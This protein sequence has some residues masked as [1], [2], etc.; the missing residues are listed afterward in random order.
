VLVLFERDDA[1]GQGQGP[2]PAQAR[3]AGEPGRAGHLAGGAGPLG[4]TAGGAGLSF[5]PI[6]SNE[7]FIAAG[8]TG[9]RLGPIVSA[10]LVGRLISYTFWVSTAH[11]AA[12]RFEDLF[13][14][15]LRTG[16]A[17][18]LELVALGLLVLV[19][20]L[21][22]RRCAVLNGQ[23]GLG[24]SGTARPWG[25]SSATPP[26]LPTAAGRSAWARPPR[27]AQD[28]MSRSPLRQPQSVARR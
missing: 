19:A 3:A 6:P 15:H 25:R 12:Q 16:S 8:L 21:D 9:M 5:G 7:L 17:L 11:L 20:R 14:G 4:G 13:A 26:G 22:W 23:G 1:G 27:Q 10:F 28:G 24:R 18:I 2:P